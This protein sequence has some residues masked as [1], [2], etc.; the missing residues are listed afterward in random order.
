MKVVGHDTWVVRIPYEERRAATHIV[1]Q[2]N[3][4]EGAQGISYLTPLVPWTVAP[5]RAA[6]DALMERVHGADPMAVESINAALLAR[7]VRPQ[8]DGL[9]R[10]AVSVIDIAL[11]DLKAK[12][13]SQPLYRLL[14]G[15][16]NKVPTYAAWHLWL[17]SA[18][19]P[20]TL[21]KNGR[22]HVARGFR[23]M[24]FHVGPIPTSAEVVAR[25]RALREAV[26]DDIELYLDMNWSR[27]VNNAIALGRELAP[28]NLA[29]IE[30]P[31]LSND[32]DG[33]RQISE[34]LETP[35]CAGETFH[36]ALE[37]R[38]LL[39]RRGVDVVMID[40]EVGGITQWLKMAH[41]VEA[42]RVPVTTHV[43]TEVSAHVI[44]AVNGVTA[45]Y[46]P[47]AEP[48]FKEGLP[49]QD[50][51]LVLFERPGLGL[52]LDPKALKKFAQ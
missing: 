48:L 40:L 5:I 8:F 15:S 49:V 11:W 10:S 19:D 35:I 39:D 46:T 28:F 21:A 20:E 1:L 17:Q 25:T 52:E 2:L 4:D 31:V 18:P 12:A 27:T 45:A 16:N 7:A 38:S 30:D 29:W 41:L 24:K 3:T 34:A 44:A 14:G 43:T 32:Y 33:L 22:A 42:Y 51:Q 6:I 9:A 50:G 13:L 37:F 36:Q 23:A 26:G 47:W